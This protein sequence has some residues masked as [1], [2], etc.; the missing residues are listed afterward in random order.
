MKPLMKTITITDIR[1][2]KPC[3]DLSKHLPEDWQGT[4]LDI[5]KMDTIPAQDRFWVVLREELIDAK[6]LRLFAVWCARQVQHLITDPRSIAAIDTAEKYA[7]GQATNEELATARD[8]AWDAACATAGDA[9][10]YA[11]RDAAWDAA[12]YAAWDA[13]RAAAHAAA[14]DAAWDAAG[15]AAG[16]AA[17]DAAQQA[18]QDAQVNQLINMLEEAEL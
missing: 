2:W 17:W 1:S 12:W 15:N 9:A 13:A 10:G 14:G 6:T 7:N 4:V 16:N 11:A 18:A 3:Y 5:L 8:A